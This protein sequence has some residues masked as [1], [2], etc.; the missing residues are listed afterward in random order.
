MVLSFC[1]EFWETGTRAS[2]EDFWP[3]EDTQLEDEGAGGGGCSWGPAKDRVG[4]GQGAAAVV[5]LKCPASGESVR[6]LPVI[7]FD[8]IYV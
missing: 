7:M 8:Q 6:Q 2:S 4:L 1:C 5:G 3:G